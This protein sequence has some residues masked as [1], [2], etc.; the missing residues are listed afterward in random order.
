M[1]EKEKVTGGCACGAIRYAYTSDEI[2]ALNCHCRDCQRASG[3][4]FGA[5]VIVWKEEFEMLDGELKYY[6]KKSDAGNTMQ[7]GFCADCGSPMTIFEP[8]RPKLIFLH[9]A[10][11]D[12]PSKHQ[13]TMDIFTDS[14]H[15]WDIL[16][17]EIQKFPGMPPVPDEL[18]R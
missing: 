4:A 11:L 13:P 6:T 2:L 17:P 14:A 1:S 10:S 12:D 3:S 15:P 9:A 7:R 16:D 8:H 18:G 5:L